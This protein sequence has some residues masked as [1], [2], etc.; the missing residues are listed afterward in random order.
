MKQPAPC[1]N[2]ANLDSAFD[3]LGRLIRARIKGET[4]AADG[5]IRLLFFNDGSPLGDFI[6]ERQPPFD[7]YMLLLLA[8]APHVRPTLLDNEIRAALT[9][10]GDFP[11]IGGIR[12]PDIRAL[13]PTGET[14]AF[15]LAGDDL[16][17]RFE[18]QE[19][20]C[21]DHWF[22]REGVL[23]LEEAKDSAP[24]LSGRIVMAR[25]WVERFTLGSAQ[26]PA[27]GTRFPA[28]RI[29]TALDWDDLVLEA[30]VQQRITELKHW[31]RHSRTLTHD[32]GMAGRLRPGYRALFHG[33]PGTG[34]TLTAT[35][36]GK[37]T[38]REVYRVDLST[39]VSKYIGETE[40]NLAALF[41]QAR[42]RDWI[43]FFDE[44]DALFGKRTSVKDAHDR[45][46]NQEVSYLLQR[47]EEF[48]GLVILASNF[49][50][51]IDD[52][53]QRRFN[54]I[55]RFP[56]PSEAER[57]EIWIRALPQEDGRDRL[58]SLLARFELSGGN[59]VNVV[60]FAAIEAIAAGCPAI[61]LDDAVMGVQREFEKEGKV[62]RN[63]L[64]EEPE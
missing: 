8:L 62:F 21:A 50:T 27:F 3:V 10:E 38:G 52:A 26:A 7:E 32:W 63:L 44:A 30:Q 24:I 25:E 43:L 42:N 20:F 9:R 36:L 54:A 5:E 17:M 41:D 45:Y 48:D 46:A 6:R 2:A 58:A 56:F 59:I 18:L 19:R 39:V 35:L 37:A 61:R 1:S 64:E 60:Q 34:K 57:R 23:R 28:R 47:V 14:A 12:D 4:F 31:V 22:A 51:N 13:L 15:L 53:F 11:E 40:K 49:H 33:P 16:D 29:A 55:I